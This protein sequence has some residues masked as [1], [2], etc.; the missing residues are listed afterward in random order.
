VESGGAPRS[1]MGKPAA[2]VSDQPAAQ[3][4]PHVCR[5]GS[6][7]TVGAPTSMKDCITDNSLNPTCLSAMYRTAWR[8]VASR[9]TFG[10]HGVLKWLLQGA[11]STDRRP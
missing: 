5:C 6:G 10:N 4:G 9:R 7:R 3:H 1:E 11:V 8:P 2:A